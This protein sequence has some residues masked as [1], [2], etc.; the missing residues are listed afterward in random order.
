M[1]LPNQPVNYTGHIDAVTFD[2]F[3]NFAKI[4]LEPFEKEMLMDKYR[5]DSYAT[6]DLINYQAL[7]TDMTQLKP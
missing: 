2:R 4:N 5:S 3:L 6:R 7:V 1:K